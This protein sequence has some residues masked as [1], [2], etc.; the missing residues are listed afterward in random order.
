MRNGW[1]RAESNEAAGASGGVGREAL[2]SYAEV[3]V[4]EPL[5]IGVV[6]EGVVDD[7]VGQETCVGEVEVGGMGTGQ[8]WMTEANDTCIG[9]IAGVCGHVNQ[10]DLLLWYGDVANCNSVE[11]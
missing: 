10:A 3:W 4:D 6:E 2:E 5:L 7:F 8:D 1:K 9:A 11:A